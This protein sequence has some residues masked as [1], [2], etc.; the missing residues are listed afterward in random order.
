MQ[1]SN[2]VSSKTK[3][4]TSIRN[5]KRLLNKL[6]FQEDEIEEV[7]RSGKITDKRLLSLTESDKTLLHLKLKDRE[8]AYQEVMRANE[9]L[10][11]SMQMKD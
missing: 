9:K 6:H 3:A 2:P 5:L 10:E 11:A 4:E 7:C 8:T 1:I